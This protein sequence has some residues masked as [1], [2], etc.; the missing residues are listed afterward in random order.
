MGDFIS[1]TLYSK[2][3]KKRT[4]SECDYIC[5]NLPKCSGYI[6]DNFNNRCYMTT[7]PQPVLTDD[8][9]GQYTAY[10]NTGYS[11][12]IRGT[13]YQDFIDDSK[14]TQSEMYSQ[15]ACANS[16]G[17]N[18]DCGVSIFKDNQC[19][20]NKCIL[21]ISIDDKNNC[22]LPTFIFYDP[23]ATGHKGICPNGY[24]PCHTCTTVNDTLDKYDYKDNKNNTG[25][26]IQI[27][28]T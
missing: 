15:K 20:N 26:Y 17:N 22:S 3:N 4:A 28:N 11:K 16:C 23:Q 27:K 25:S 13:V 5:N 10:V 19:C 6:Y 18:T 2:N 14:N 8:T 7:D 21:P 12:L 24:Y 1:E 9:T